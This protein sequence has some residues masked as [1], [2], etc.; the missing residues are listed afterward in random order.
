M[1]K[2]QDLFF[3]KAINNSCNHWHF[4][5]FNQDFLEFRFPKC[6]MSVSALCTHFNEYW[7]GHKLHCF[8]SKNISKI[9]RGILGFIFLSV[10]VPMHI[11]LENGL[12]KSTAPG[13][14][15]PI[16]YT[17]IWEILMKYHSTT[18]FLESPQ[19]SFLQRQIGSWPLSHNS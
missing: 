18:P 7:F 15:V 11:H 9:Q 1:F 12:A 19:N 13:Q 6:S 17:Y 4:W 8:V 5:T 16:N 2:F 10:W 3:I 14:G